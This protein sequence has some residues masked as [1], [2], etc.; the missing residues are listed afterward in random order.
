MTRAFPLAAA[1][2]PL[3]LAACS[4]IASVRE[5]TP[6]GRCGEFMQQAFPGGDITVTKT[7]VVPVETQSIATIVAAAEGTRKN[8]A[9][10]GVPLREV[11]VEC[12]F[13]EGI[14]TG[15]RW[16]KGPLR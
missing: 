14:L 6:T 11:A 8:V 10:N 7:A 9:P 4:L 15:F 16:T 1:L 5:E 3:A 13:N 12:R 2:L